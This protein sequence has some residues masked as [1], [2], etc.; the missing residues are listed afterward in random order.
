MAD[1]FWSRWPIPAHA[2]RGAAEDVQSWI[3]LGVARAAIAASARGY[4]VLVG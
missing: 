2:Y 3:V 4:H 1:C